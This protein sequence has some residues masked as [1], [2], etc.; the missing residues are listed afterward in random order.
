MSYGIFF[1]PQYPV[2]FVLLILLPQ[3]NEICQGYWVIGLVSYIY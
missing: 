1:Y 3:T 2:L